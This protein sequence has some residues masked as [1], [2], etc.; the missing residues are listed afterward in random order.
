MEDIIGHGD[1]RRGETCRHVLRTA[2]YHQQIVLW[3]MPGDWL[4]STMLMPA[5]FQEGIEAIGTTAYQTVGATL[6]QLS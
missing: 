3:K 4:L 2:A 6:F 1:I 5:G